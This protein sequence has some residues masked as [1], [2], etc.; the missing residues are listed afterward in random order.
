[1]SDVTDTSH[2]QNPAP[3]FSKWSPLH[4]ALSFLALAEK[5]TTPVYA[6][7][8]TTAAVASLLI[9]FFVTSVAYSWGVPLAIVAATIDG[10]LLGKWWEA[11]SERKRKSRARR[12]LK[13]KKHAALGTA[14]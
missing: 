8:A 6:A 11:R 7:M 9:A 2:A 14:N 13:H 3:S 4:R 1:M 5:F 10:G 12:Q